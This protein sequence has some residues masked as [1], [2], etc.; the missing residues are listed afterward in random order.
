M[1]STVAAGAA[2]LPGCGGGG[3]ADCIYCD[4]PGQDYEECDSDYCNYFDEP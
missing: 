1:A 3:Y 4:A 2:S